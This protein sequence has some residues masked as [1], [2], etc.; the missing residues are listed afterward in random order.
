MLEGIACLSVCFICKGNITTALESIYARRYKIIIIKERVQKLIQ[1][2]NNITN[3][4]NIHEITV[5]AYKIH[6]RVR[7]GKL[8]LDIKKETV[9]NSGTDR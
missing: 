6:K 9:W 5:L 8:Y 4:I 2:K 7:K 3:P 1:D